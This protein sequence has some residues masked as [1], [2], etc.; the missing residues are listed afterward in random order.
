MLNT[1]GFNKNNNNFSKKNN[2]NKLSIVSS[3]N[4]QTTNTI[5]PLS[6]NKNDEL[7]NNIE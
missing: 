4:E 7:Q 3:N 2:F 1:K 5:I 6:K